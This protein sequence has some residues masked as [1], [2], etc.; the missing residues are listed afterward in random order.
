M[1][2]QVLAGLVGVTGGCAWIG[3]R[4]AWIIG[5]LSGG[6]AVGICRFMAR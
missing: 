6:L 2:E 3:Y 5:T 4:D 1:A